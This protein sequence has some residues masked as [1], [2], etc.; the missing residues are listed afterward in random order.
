METLIAIVGKRLYYH[1]EF[2]CHSILCFKP[3]HSAP[4]TNK[5]NNELTKIQCYSKKHS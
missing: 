5:A 1:T 3:T 4:K 2:L